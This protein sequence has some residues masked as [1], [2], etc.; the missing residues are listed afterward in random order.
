[1]VKIISTQDRGAPLSP[2][3]TSWVYNG[4]DCAVTAEIWE[5][6]QPERDPVADAI[7]F[8]ERDLQGP[9][10]EMNMN[11]ILVDAEELARFRFEMKRE[12]DRLETIL[13]KLLVEGYGLPHT[14][15]IPD[16]NWRSPKQL[17]WFIYDYLRCPPQRKR[18]A[19]GTFGRTTDRNALEKLLS[20]YPA[21]PFITIVLKMR[22]IAK[23]LGFIETELDPDGYMRCNYNIAGTNTGRLSSSYSDTGTGT[24]LQNVKRRLRQIFVSEKGTIFVSLDLEQADSRN[25]GAECWNRFYETHGPAFAGAYL[26]ACESGD[27]HTKVTRLG[28]QDLDWGS[29]ERGFR[30]VADRIAYRDLSYRD[31]AKRLGHGTNYYGQPPTMAAHTKIPVAIAA[32][33][34]QRYFAAFPCIREWH[35]SVAAELRQHGCLTTI[36]GRRRYFFGRLNEDKTLREAIAY[37][38]QSATAEETN[39]GLLRIWREGKRFP[40]FKLRSQV[41]DSVKFEVREDCVE[42]AVEWAREALRVELR[43]VGDRIFSVPTEA[44]VGWNWADWHPG[45]PDGLKKW[46]GPDNRTRSREPVREVT[47]R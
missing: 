9:V 17:D 5:A 13:N 7:Y 28:W 34:Q 43:L 1:M 21:V 47:F 10:L 36:W 35:R 30:A 44:K 3:E 40:R 18:R 8:L 14:N 27:L 22:D 19:N 39:K 11:G 2:D 25:V 29:D 24:N 46:K 6:L 38:G 42:E 33:F 32:D 12:L 31:L 16:L 45:N 4:L 26:D 37:L 15:G 41:H 20:V 23:E